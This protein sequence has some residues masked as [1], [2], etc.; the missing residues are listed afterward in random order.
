MECKNWLCQ[1]L[2]FGQVHFGLS[3]MG[4]MY[5]HPSPEPFISSVEK[6]NLN[7]SLTDWIRIGR[8]VLVQLIRS[9]QVRSQLDG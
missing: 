2:R 9:N 6:I 1:F 4:V 5:A 7:I 8:Q 3:T